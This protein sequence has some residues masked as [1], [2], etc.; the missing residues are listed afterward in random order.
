MREK[1]GG[2]TFG[3]IT[4]R[5]YHSG[6]VNALLADGSV[7]FVKGSVQGNVWRALGSRG[8]AEIISGTD[9]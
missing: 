7:R 9:F 6:G 3:A 1:K 4:A 5:S 8:L 2:P